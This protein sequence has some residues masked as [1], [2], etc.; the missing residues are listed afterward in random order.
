MPRLDRRRPGTDG[1]SDVP[2][3]RGPVGD[4]ARPDVE[5]QRVVALILVVGRA[6]AEPLRGRPCEQPLAPVHREHEHACLVAVH[7]E[8]SGLVVAQEHDRLGRVDRHANLGI[9]SAQEPPHPPPQDQ[10]VGLDVVHNQ[11]EAPVAELARDPLDV[12]GQRSVRSGRQVRPGVDQAC[13]IV[14]VEAH[15]DGPLARNLSD[16]RLCAIGAGH[17]NERREQLIRPDERGRDGTL[18]AHRRLL[19]CVASE[20]LPERRVCSP[21][22][23]CRA[24]AKHLD[25]GH[26]TAGRR[27]G[28]GDGFARTR[29]PAARVRC[30]P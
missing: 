19:P 27:G 14:D 17:A 25:P 6:E 21:G 1:L 8:R 26:C 5:H 29:R 22:G 7:A 20:A 11:L 16:P 15:A 18:E 10:V 30:R 23:P 13:G 9:E 24:V 12:A 4:V 2:M 3:A 28:H